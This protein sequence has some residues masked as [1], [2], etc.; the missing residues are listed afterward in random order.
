[1]PPIHDDSS[2]GDDAATVAAP[3]SADLLAQQQSGSQSLNDAADTLV[4]TQQ[5]LKNTAEA[6]APA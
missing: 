2:A 3:A 4:A 6:A 1:M 5:T